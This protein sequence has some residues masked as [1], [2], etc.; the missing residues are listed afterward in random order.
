MA[1]RMADERLVTAVLEHLLLARASSQR[2]AVTSTSQQAAAASTNSQN[3]CSWQACKKDTEGGSDPWQ[4][5]AFAAEEAHAEERNLPDADGGKKR[6][7]ARRVAGLR[8]AQAV[9]R[10]LLLTVAGAA[11]RTACHVAASGAQTAVIVPSAAATGKAQHEPPAQPTVRGT[12][13]GGAAQEELSTPELP[14]RMPQCP[15]SKA[16]R[17][18]SVWA[19][20]VCNVAPS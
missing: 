14:F 2:R 16:G 7:A 4:S 11:A 5:R 17:R 19:P 18:R 12:Q 6:A 20:A 8:A 13:I 10:R 1:R 15:P 3:Q 9:R